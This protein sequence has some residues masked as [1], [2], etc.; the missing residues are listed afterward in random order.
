MKKRMHPK[1]ASPSAAPAETEPAKWLY[2]LLT[3]ACAAFLAV[4]FFFAARQ[5]FAS[6]DLGMKNSNLRKQI[7]E[8]ESQKRQLTLAR[9]MVRSPAEMKRIATNKGFRERQTE[10]VTIAERVS[11]ASNPLIARTSIVN[12]TSGD[13]KPIKA[14]F[15]MTTQSKAPSPKEKKNKVER[16]VAIDPK[17]LAVN[18]FR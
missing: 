17:L 10:T 6:M 8:M 11:T 15:P 9:E 4:G 2:I 3:I 14:F 12:A 13:K 1:Y 7:E 18:S 16:R 5:H